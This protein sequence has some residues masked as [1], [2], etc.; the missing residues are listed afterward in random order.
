M[1]VNGL[2]NQQLLERMGPPGLSGI[3]QFLC[4]IKGYLDVFQQ[5]LLLYEGQ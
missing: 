5:V 1:G 4:Y 2:A 3:S